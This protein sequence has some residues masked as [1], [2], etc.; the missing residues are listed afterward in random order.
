MARYH[1]CPTDNAGVKGSNHFKV[2]CY[3]MVDLTITRGAKS[4]IEA[5]AA[6]LHAI[7]N[8]LHGQMVGR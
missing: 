5:W 4:P 3:F 2:S 7:F 8:K 1:D 6:A